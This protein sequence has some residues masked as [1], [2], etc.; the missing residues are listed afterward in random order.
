MNSL[1]VVLFIISGFVE[2]QEIGDPVTVVMAM[3][4]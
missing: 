3:W 2:G 4:G 1:V